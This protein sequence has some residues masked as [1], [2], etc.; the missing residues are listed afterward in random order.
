LV[1]WEKRSLQVLK[2]I[3]LLQGSLNGIFLIELLF[4]LSLIQPYIVILEKASSGPKELLV[5][6]WLLPNVSTMMM[7][8]E[9]NTI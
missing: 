5:T 9:P 2:T 1:P 8:T 7:M 4:N 3:G 6:K